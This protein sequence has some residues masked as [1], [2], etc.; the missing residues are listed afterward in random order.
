MGLALI[1][2]VA[3]V[4]AGCDKPT[5]SVG[6]QSGRT[7]VHTSATQYEFDGGKV[8]KRSPSVPSITVVPGGTVNVDVSHSIAKRGYYLSVGGQRIT[9]TIT[10]DH[11]RLPVANT[12]GQ[13]QIVLFQAPKKGSTS[14][15]GSWVFNLKVAP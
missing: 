13:A 5:P 15:S 6:I 2:A 7:W 8:A 11:Y 10:S 9:D 3:V 4:V 14:A 12:N 1:G